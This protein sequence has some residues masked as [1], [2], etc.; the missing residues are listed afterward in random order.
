MNEHLILKGPSSKR[1]DEFWLLSIGAGN[2][3]GIGRDRQRPPKNSE[4]ALDACKAEHTSLIG[5][6]RKMT[7]LLV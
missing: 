3:I 1:R 7:S 4:I 5:S 2:F 6:A